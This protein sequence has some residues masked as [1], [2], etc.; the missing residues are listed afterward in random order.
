MTPDRW[1]LALEAG[2]L[3]LPDGPCLVMRARGDGDFGSLGPV[4]C[5]QGF[6]P[7][8]DLLAAR[9]LTVTPDLPEGEVFAAALVQ[10]VK[11]K[12]GTL[13]SIAEALGA[14]RPGGVLMVDGSKEVKESRSIPEGAEA[15]S[16]SA[17]T[18]SKAHWASWCG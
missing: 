18:F 9:G 17:R 16:R 4:H 11:A 5:V 2:E 6:A 12:A 13:G 15:S 8:H 14:L 7:D 3:A 10:I 1:T